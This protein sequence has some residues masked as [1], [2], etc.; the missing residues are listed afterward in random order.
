MP[1][2]LT[3]THRELESVARAFLENVNARAAARALLDAPTEELPKFW[4]ELAALGWLGLHLPEDVGGSGYGL[5]ELVVVLQELG[6]AVAP[7]PFLPTVMAS[8]VIAM[9]GSDAQRAALLPRLA[10]GSRIAALG[11]GGGLTLDGGTVRGDGGAVL[12]AGL[13]ELLVLVA[14]DD[15]V[16]LDRDA[17]GLSVTVAGNLDPTRRVGRV[18]ARDVAVPR[19]PGAAGRGVGCARRRTR[20]RVRRSGRR[21]AGMRRARDRVREGAPA[22]RASDR[23]VPGGEAPLRQ[24]ARGIGARDGRGVGRRARRT[25]AVTSSRSRPRSPRCSRFPRSSA[26]RSST[27]R[28][29]AASASRG[30]TTATCCCAAR[31]RWSRCSMP[32]L[33]PGT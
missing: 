32:R 28:C 26:T 23:D 4:D 20:A 21:R 16:V 6:R 17:A 15:V 9:A 18:G 19:R 8:T 24:H 12:G 10:D 1:I 7:G 13:A 25:V 30:S 11:L 14:G 3:D 31:P 2:A 22:V 29:T 5:A 27:S 33:P